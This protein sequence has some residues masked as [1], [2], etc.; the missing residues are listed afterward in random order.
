MDK[1]SIKSLASLLGKLASKAADALPGIIGSIISWL[2]NRAK[3]S[4]GMV[5]SKSLGFD[6]WCWWID[7]YVYGY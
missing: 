2:L 1:R 5:V 4:C 3:G 7:L 6:C